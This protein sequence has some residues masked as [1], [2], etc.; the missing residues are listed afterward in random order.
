MPLSDYCMV[1]PQ[2]G[3]IKVEL[4]V[5][6]GIRSA[7]KFLLWEQKN[8]EWKKKENFQLITGD[9]GIED[10]ILLEKPGDIE[11]DLL[12]WNINACAQIPNAIMGTFEVAIYQDGKKLWNKTSVQNNVTPCQ[13][14]SILFGNE[15]IFKHA[16]TNLENKLNLWK[17]IENT[18]L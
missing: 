1:N 17:S 5:N 15:V 16:I 8:G 18:S 6:N 2:G 4:K 7:S 10:K 12:A 9:D 3:A 14:G 13:K 11:N